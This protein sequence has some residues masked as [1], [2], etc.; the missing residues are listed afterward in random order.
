MPSTSHAALTEALDE[1]SLVDHHVHGALIE[2]VDLAGLARHCAETDRLAAAG[3]SYL[4]SQL[5]L[6]IRR[7]CAPLLGLEAHAPIEQYVQRRQ[8]LGVDEVNRRLLSATGI[9]HYLL[10]TGYRGDEILSPSGMATATGVAVDEVVRLESL[11]E[12]LVRSGSVD[13][14]T[15]VDAY[16]DY[17]SRRT[18]QAVGTKTILAY[19]YGFDIDPTRP[20]EADVATAAGRWL[21]HVERTG[22]VRVDDPVLLRHV[23]WAGLDRG[24]PLQVHTGFG[25]PDLDLSRSDPAQLTPLIKAAEPT[26]TPILLLH[27]YPFA[28]QAGYLARSFTNVYMDVGEGTHYVGARAATIVGQSLELAPFGKVLFSSDA[29]GP[30]ELHVLGAGGWRRGFAA[31]ASQWVDDGEWT[32]ADAIRV[33]QLIGADNARRVYALEEA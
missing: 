7:Y 29:W 6:S 8:A 20:A 12:E 23:I 5:G 3:T 18:A 21:D 10:E 27:T 31:V 28:R 19:R 26:G 14:A 11:A 17:L 33:A 24:L 4:D 1:I 9:G 2:D 32:L 16:G 30:A 22:V 25:D 13:P 15:F